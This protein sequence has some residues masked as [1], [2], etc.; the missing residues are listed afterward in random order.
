[1]IGKQTIVLE[2]RLREIFAFLPTIKGFQPVFKQGDHKELI[3]FFQESQGNTNY[4]LIWLDMPYEEE[5]LNRKRVKVNSL[6]LILAVQ[7]NSEMRYSERLETTFATVLMPLLD[8]VLDAF[9]VAN[10]LSYDSNYKIVKFGNYSE[11]AEG[12]EGAFVDI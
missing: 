9:T 1:M 5:H 4:P 6:N 12:T 8:S 11:Q 2:D 7:T 3:A 10:T